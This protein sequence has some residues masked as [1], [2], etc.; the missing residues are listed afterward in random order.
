[1]TQ[2]IRM[3]S[4]FIPYKKIIPEEY[5]SSIFDIDYNRLYSQGLRLI[6]TD[7]DNTLI[8]YIAT[9]PT[10][11]LFKWK[12]M[13]EEIGFEVIIVSNS[14]KD[15]VEYFAKQLNLPFVK[16]AKKP[17]KFGFKKALKMASRHYD[18]SEVLELGDQLLTDVF[19]SKRMKFYT[20]L[21]KAIDRKTEKWVTRFNRGLEKKVIA[22]A[23]KKDY[24]LYSKTLAQ[25]ERDNI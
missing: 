21:V 3:I 9:S 24:E 2:V 20:V 23:K 22:R 5:V 8:S 17:T 13:V 6:L 10:E 25:Y 7:L 15:R 19:G 18:S 14:R 11:E 16:F 4:K 1:M 12:K